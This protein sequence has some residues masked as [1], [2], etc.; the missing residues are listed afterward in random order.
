MVKLL[1][2]IKHHF[3]FLWRFIEW[4]NA[5]LFTFLH[6]TKFEK[7][8]PAVISE[9][10]HPTFKARKLNATDLQ[11]LHDFISFQDPSRL[12]YFKPHAF[13]EKS[14]YNVF[15]NPAFLMMGVFDGPLMVGY[16][17]LRCFWNRKCFVGRLVNQDYE[18]KGIG[19]L[20]NDIM[21]NIAWKSGFRC[22]STISK[23][24]NDVM[25]AHANNH[26]MVILKELDNDYLFVEF[27][28]NSEIPTPEI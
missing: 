16:F 8:I 5:V 9:Y 11:L 22:L 28:K 24:N 7:N 4:I 21:Y 27:I 26:T 1:L 17:F 14:L 2:Y 18:G 12:A 15:K 13:D 23:N 25:R 10:S 20:M 6:K 3:S 19:R